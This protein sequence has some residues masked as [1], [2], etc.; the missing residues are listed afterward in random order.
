MLDKA[1]LYQVMW[2]EATH[3]QKESLEETILRM[4]AP[5]RDFNSYHKSQEEIKMFIRMQN[6]TKKYGEGESTVYA[7]DHTGLE[8]EKGEICVILGPSGSGKSTM[9]NMLGGLDHLDEG[10]IIVGE[11]NLSGYRSK[12]LTEYRK[13]D[14]GFVF[15][16]YKG[17]GFLMCTFR[18][19]IF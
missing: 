18:K 8:I 12:K 11:R 16:F 10:E 6:A 14:V 2:R 19:R 13:E 7:L 5:N 4:W 1:F 17:Y 3:E 15:Q 9:L